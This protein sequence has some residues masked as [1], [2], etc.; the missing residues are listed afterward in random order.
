MVYDLMDDAP[1]TLISNIPAKKEIKPPALPFERQFY[2][3]DV[4]S[5]LKEWW[6]YE[7]EKKR[8]WE[9]NEIDQNEIA[10]ALRGVMNI[11]YH[12]MKRYPEHFVPAEMEKGLLNWDVII[13]LKRNFQK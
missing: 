10:A 7:V 12:V 1:S 9:I 2:T 13:Q 5:P 3:T 4:I 8:R 11:W 6:D